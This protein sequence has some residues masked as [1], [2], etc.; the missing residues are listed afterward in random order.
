MPR[1]EATSPGRLVEPRWVTPVVLLGLVLLGGIVRIAVAGQDLFADELATYWIATSRSFTGVVDTV[2]TTAEI[3]PPLSFLLT[4]LSTRL[5]TSPELVR[6]P[7]LV[8]GVASIPLVYALGVRTVGR[9]AALLAA[10]LTTL[11]PFMIFYSAEARGYGV[12]MALVLLSTLA[13]LRAVEGGGIRWWVLYGAAV[14]LASYTHYTAVYVLAA[15]VGWA[16]WTQ[17]SA[18]RA[19]LVATGV[20]ALLFLPWLPSLKADVDSPTTVILGALSPLDGHSIRLALGQWSVGFPGASFGVPLPFEISG[21]SLR[22]LPGDPALVLL[23]ASACVGAVGAFTMR[24]RLQAW[25]ADHGGRLS[26]VVLLALASPVGAAI[27]SVVGTNVFRTRTFAA[28]WPYLALATAALVTVG[29]PALRVSAAALALAAF[30]MATVTMLRDDF[31]RPGYSTVVHLV[32]GQAPGVVVNGAAFTP[33]PLTDLDVEGSVPRDPVLRVNVPE[34]M[35]TPFTLT[36][37]RPDPADVAARAVAA[38][39]G[40]P[41]TVVS[42]IPALPVVTELIDHLPNEYELTETTSIPGIFDLEVR[43]YRADAAAA[44]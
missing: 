42:F 1:G 11:S 10:A 35:E 37:R 33:G 27:Q 5:G 7:A 12:L 36:E 13:L 43:V 14:C 38:A 8:A 25:F 39:D 4:W 44:P 28:S 15:Q 2:T 23:A 18:R 31:H 6:L 21:S 29:R 16:L 3:T 30:A 26:L 17:P 20:P 19:V 24:T 40:G 41:I 22:D 9:E 32:D 34:Q